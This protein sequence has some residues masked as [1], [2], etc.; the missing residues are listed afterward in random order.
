LLTTQQGLE[1]WFLRQATFTKPDG[2]TRG[3]ELR[4]QKGDNYQWLWHG[5]PDE[6]LEKGNV[7]EINEGKSFAFSFGRA[8]NVK[9][10]LLQEK[11]QTVV[12]L[13][14]ENIPTNAESQVEFH[15]GCTKGWLFYLTN[16]KSIVE[17]GIDLRNRDV[18][19]KDVVN[20]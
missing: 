14:Q 2:T 1:T 6:I 4:V 7:I 11:G 17:G 19:L 13:L 10:S 3:R 18:E 8:G 16:L 15:I 20:S 5:W 9:I 12:E